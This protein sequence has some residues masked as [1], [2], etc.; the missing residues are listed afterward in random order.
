MRRRLLGLIAAVGLVVPA[1]AMA[2]QPSTLRVVAHSDL[3]ILDPIWTTAY[4]TR[5]HGYMVY[6]VLFATDAKGEVQPQM[7]DKYT[8]SDDKLKW[9]FTLRDGLV[10]HDGAPV[11]GSGAGDQIAL[12]VPGGEGDVLTI[13]GTVDGAVRSGPWASTDGETGTWTVTRN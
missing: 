6:D 10:F 12:T 8:V 9:T 7:V 1:G 11:T 4:I 13:E 2:Q 5:N 3:K